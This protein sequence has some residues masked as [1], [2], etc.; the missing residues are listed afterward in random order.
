MNILV[1]GNGFDLEHDLPTKYT[2]FLD[3]LEDFSNFNKWGKTKEDNAQSAYIKNLFES[4]ENQEKLN[5]LDIFTHDNLWIKYFN[6]VREGH[7]K[8]QENWIDFEKEISTIIQAYNDL[9]QYH[10]NQKREDNKSEKFEKH[11]LDILGEIME[12]YELAEENRKNNILRLLE[13]LNKLAGALELYIWDYI[14]NLKLDYY[15]PSIS[16]IL[17]DKVLSFNYSD[18][19]GILYDDHRNGVE[20][21][22]VHGKAENNISIFR[23]EECMDEK[24]KKACI[25]ANAEN[26]N[27]VLGIDE[28]LPEDRRNKEMDF[29]A[30]KKYYQR[31]Y[32]K[33]GNEYKKWL[34]EVDE[35]KS[36]KNTVY[37]FGHSLDE[38]DGDVLRELINHANM[39][40]VIFYRNKEQLGQQ[41]ANL[42]KI[43]KSDTVI[44]KVYG[45]NPSIIFRQQ[46][47]R[48]HIE[49]SAFEIRA[50]IWKLYMIFRCKNLEVE[51]L[52]IKIKNKAEKEDLKYFYSQELVISLFNVLQKNGLARFYKKQLLEVA[53]KLMKCEG[54]REP[55]MFFR[56]QWEYNDCFGEH[57]CDLDT[58]SF[59][60]EINEYNKKNF[61]VGKIPLKSVDERLEE[62]REMVNARK[63]ISKDAYIESVKDIFGMFVDSNVNT[64]ELWDVLMNVSSGPAKKVARETLEELLR[65]EE[66]QVNIIRYENMLQEF[67]KRE[68]IESLYAQRQGTVDEYEEE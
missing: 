27:M 18:T 41:I 62:Y 45:S 37:I 28:Y 30:F 9:I 44:E 67:I 31:I 60:D 26:N 38:T 3:F 15:N 33:T 5:A 6:K 14:G 20:Y 22:F 1:L 24:G 34:Q 29:I 66:S 8:R 52:L 23:A 19:F 25:R 61:A 21:C 32:K 53:C 10:E 2:N 51:Q 43:L 46:K 36:N 47:E 39:N 49:G 63:E 57:P 12:S 17:V 42:V 68:Y 48:E 56:W 16:D 65:N 35:H 64:K 50:D 58:A 54:L 13:D 55:K 40:T 4:V 11:C 7:M 59:I